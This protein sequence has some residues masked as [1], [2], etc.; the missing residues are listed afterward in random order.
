MVKSTKKLRESFSHSS[1]RRKHWTC[2]NK[3]KPVTPLKKQFSGSLNTVACYFGTVHYF[4]T[5]LPK[6]HDVLMLCL[7]G[8]ESRSIPYHFWHSHIH[9][10]RNTAVLTPAGPKWRMN[11]L[12]FIC[13]Q[14]G[15]QTCW[16]TQFLR[17]NQLCQIILQYDRKH[18]AEVNSIL[19]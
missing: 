11:Y 1:L 7:Q 16:C 10:L 18:W 13:Q 19:I 15:L 14:Q 8:T 6:I 17:K 4:C 12:E 9:T 2:Y 3:C 5:L